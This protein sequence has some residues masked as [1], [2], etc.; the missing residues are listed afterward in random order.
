MLD[1]QVRPEQRNTISFMIRS[2]NPGTPGMRG[3]SGDA[4]LSGA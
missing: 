3:L 2:G 1:D 4:G